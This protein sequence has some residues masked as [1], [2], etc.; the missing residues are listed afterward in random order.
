MV[1]VMDV[2]ALRVNLWNL[3]PTL[4]HS[5]SMCVEAYWGCQ[6]QLCW[7]FLPCAFK[8]CS[9]TLNCTAAGRSQTTPAARSVWPLTGLAWP[10]GSATCALKT[11]ALTAQQG[12]CFHS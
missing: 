11:P 10:N 7:C 1:V 6:Q 12:R 5:Q 4:G 2:V 9:T 3:Q 8:C